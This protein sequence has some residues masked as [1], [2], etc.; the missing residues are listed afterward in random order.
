[1]TIAAQIADVLRRVEVTDSGH[2]VT[3]SQTY[4]TSVD[5]LWNACT[6]PERLER[7]FEPVEGDLQPGGRYR[8]T[9][10]G[11]EGTIEQC[12]APRSLSITWEYGEDV[13]RVLVSIDEAETGTATLTIRH[14]GDNNEDWQTYGP[15]AGGS[16]WDTSLLG[17][18]L[19]LQNDPP[20]SDI[21]DLMASDDGAQFLR[22]T[23]A[24]WRAAHEAAGAEAEDAGE[25]AE[26]AIEQNV[27]LWSAS[28]DT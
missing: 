6:T 7:W 26:R 25:R 4:R 23:G 3:I 5:D 12:E 20:M 22:A 27:Q 11:T 8:L 19:H 28:D 15:A 2:V 21:V 1:M 17:L 18:A 10:S 14:L 16:G 9:E 24:A 13:S